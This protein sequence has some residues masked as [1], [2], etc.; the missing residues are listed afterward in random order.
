MDECVSTKR[1]ARAVVLLVFA[2]AML[3]ICV[4]ASADPSPAR[5]QKIVFGSNR[6]DGQRDLYTV[7]EDGSGERRLTF[8][9]DEYFERQAV[10][11]PDGTRIAYA[12]RDDGNFDIYT[13]D[14]NGG[15][16]RRV[17]IDL[18]RDDY[19]Q[20]T[21]DGRIIFTRNLFTCPCTEWI[22]GSDGSNPQNLPLAGSVGSA[23]ASSHGN[24]LV[25]ASAV[26]G[27]SSLRV[28]QLGSK[29]G[30]LVSGDHQITNGPA[31]FGDFEPRWSPSGNDIVFLRDHNGVD[32]DIYVVHADGTGLRQLTNTPSR[33]EFWATW[34]SDGSEVLFQDGSTG[35][36]RA[37]S[38]AT[39]AERSVAT[40]PQAPLTEAFSG[41]V[42]DASLWHQISDPGGS[43]SET[44]GR[45]VATISG[46]AVPG[47]QYNQIDEHFGSQ[48]SLT[49]DYDY[50]VDYALLTWPH[51]GGFRAQV[52]A[53]FA[54]ASVGRAS[55]AI[56]WAPSWG[57]EQVQGYSDGG[58][59]SFRSSELSGTLR[60]VRHDGIATG[61]LQSG[62]GWRPVF[63]G[64]APNDTV[65]GMGLSAAAADFGHMDGAVA[66]D[67]FR[68]SSGRLTCPDWWQDTFPDVWFG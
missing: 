35:K 61:Y 31:G 2:S 41:G 54:N 66:F 40:W 28:A 36:L 38:I 10:W 59:G 50:Q 16:R 43:I 57:D 1:G 65:Y 23:D 14:A 18:Q 64:D 29:G 52:Q 48:C 68:L 27:T 20:W 12:A 67:N 62:D 55:I 47:G 39:S 22:V 5:G 63:S 8:D 26:G 34:S 32:N 3:S 7:N 15:D 19:P 53:F 21:A 49:G 44:G 25:Y 60:L 24:L 58:N 37:I 30:Q 45:L 13:V 33:P 4:G 56:P 17:T 11:S 6:A 51:L 46:S 42:R 9:G